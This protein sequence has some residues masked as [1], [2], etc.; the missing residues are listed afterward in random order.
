MWSDTFPDNRDRTLVDRLRPS[1]QPDDQTL[2]L[3]RDVRRAEG[4]E[5]IFEDAPGRSRRVPCAT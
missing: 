5:R 4:C 1:P 3:R 2:E